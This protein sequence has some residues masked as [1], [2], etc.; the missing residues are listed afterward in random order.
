ML[1]QENVNYGN[2]KAGFYCICCLLKYQSTYRV[3]NARRRK[4]RNFFNLEEY[5]LGTFC[6]THVGHAYCLVFY[7]LPL[8]N[9]V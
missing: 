2:V 4:A 1:R 6:I 3:N 7:R 9:H 8:T 5:I